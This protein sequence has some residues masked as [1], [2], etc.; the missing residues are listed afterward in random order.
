M[1]AKRQNARAARRRGESSEKSAAGGGY[2]RPPE[3][4]QFRPGMSGNPKGRPKNSRDLKRILQET[5]TSGV[6]LREGSRTRQ[7]SKLEAVVLRQVEA[8]LKGNEKAA[9]AVLRMA[10]LVDLLNG[11][12]GSPEAV[13][14]TTA[15]RKILNDLIGSTTGKITRNQPKKESN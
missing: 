15:E 13:E 12:D 3:H 5:L 7:V 9:L 1:A 14:L 6:M 10:G 11:A 8:A 4:R 2:G